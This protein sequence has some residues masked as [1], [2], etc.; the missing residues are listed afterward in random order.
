MSDELIS[1]IVPVYNAEKFL[2][3]CVQSILTQT[4]DNLDVILVNDGSY[5]NSGAICDSFAKQ[6]RRVRVI[7]KENGGVYSARN[8]GLDAIKGEFIG[9]VDSDDTIDADMYIEMFEQITEAGADICV[10]GYK[11]YKFS[12]ERFE[13]VRVPYRGK[14]SHKK[15]WESLI[16]NYSRGKQCFNPVW[17]KLYR[18]TIING[19]AFKNTKAIRFQKRYG[20]EDAY[21]NDDCFASAK[22]GVVYIDFVP[23]NF[24]VVNNVNSLSKNYIKMG[25][26]TKKLL[27]HKREVILSILPSRISEINK[28][29]D[30]QLCMNQFNMHHQAIISMHKPAYKLTW[31]EVNSI[32]QAPSKIVGPYYK[33][34]APMLKILPTSLYRASYKLYSRRYTRETR[35]KE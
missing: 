30:T 27:E 19:R 22:N 10:C 6:D 29:I 35:C 23:Y 31:S 11:N 13:S 15:F 21:F 18:R 9:F 28:V 26:G 20:V 32:I 4:H 7:H 33:V 17:N 25:E 16:E 2:E 14:I 1:V 12:S 24:I 5:D 3:S 34:S 8:A